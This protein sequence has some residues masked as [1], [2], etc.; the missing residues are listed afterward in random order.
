MTLSQRLLF[1]VVAFL[2]VFAGCTFTL[3][4]ELELH[5]PVLTGL[6]TGAPV[7]NP[8]DTGAPPLTPP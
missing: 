5:Q 2:I 6:P 1:F 7:V 8:P 3:T 4:T